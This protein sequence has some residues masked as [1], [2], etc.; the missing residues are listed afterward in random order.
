MSKEKAP[1]PD[2][3]E[4]EQQ[5]EMKEEETGQTA[6]SKPAL[7]ES[8]VL[9]DDAYCPS[10]GR[11]VGA[12]ER[13][14]YCQATMT[15][16][17][18]VKI[19]RRLA[20]AGAIIGLIMLWF[21]ARAKVP[22]EIN[23]GSIDV[24]NNMALVRV[25]GRVVGLRLVT[26]KNTFS[27]T[28]DDGS[29][30]MSLSAFDKLKAF[31]EHLGDD[32]P[33]VGD[34][35]SAVGNLSITEKWG[36]SMFLSMPRRLEMKERFTPPVRTIEAISQD[37]IGSVVEVTAHVVD[38]RQFP[39]GKPIAR[40]I[41]IRDNTGNMD[42]TV[43]NTDYEKI[44]DETT[45]TRLIKPGSKFTMQVQ[46]GDYKGRLQLKL[47]N[48]G[49]PAS[50]RYG[51]EV[52]LGPVEQVSRPTGKSSAEFLSIS[53]VTK[54]MLD[55]KVVV[56]GK[57]ESVKT[58]QPG[59]N[60]KLVDSSGTITIWLKTAIIKFHPEKDR[61]LVKGTVLRVAGIVGAFKDQLQVQ[62]GY[63]TDVQVKDSAG[64]GE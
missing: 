22:P 13:C 1:P 17:M 31:Q 38:V 55:Q 26:E 41:K 3:P 50:L 46:V 10:C 61:L 19:V 43:F 48:I 16:R 4:E 15:T 47:R 27:L 63:H 12:Y 29:G 37:D 40:S 9:P 49:S 18:G 44:P 42:L 39:P 20:V 51:G 30:R 23:I 14:P 57:V 5:V 60:V 45:M 34:I 53:Q 25:T 24:N 7:P 54:E 58:F 6:G 52:E 11:F 36:A 21:A 32:F 56:E 59:A 33:Q 8:K 2:G 64:K 62:P 28:I 35:V